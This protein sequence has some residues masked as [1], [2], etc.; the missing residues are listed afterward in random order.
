MFIN[1]VIVHS[2]VC[3]CV[4]MRERLS[5][6]AC[7]ARTVNVCVCVF[8][9]V[10]ALFISLLLSFLT[11]IVWLICLLVGT[12]ELGWWQQ[13]ENKSPNAN[14]RNKTVNKIHVWLNSYIRKRFMV[15]CVY[16]WVAHIQ[17]HERAREGETIALVSSTHTHAVDVLSLLVKE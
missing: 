17:Y 16:E 13:R 12:F 10:V 1:V 7:A 9:V 6:C 4:C 3:V 2:Y 15:F 11:L 8:V 14:R 5:M